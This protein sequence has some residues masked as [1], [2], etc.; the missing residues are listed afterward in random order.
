MALV[1]KQAAVMIPDHD[2]IGQLMV[3]ALEY[4]S[5]TS[6]LDELSTNIKKLGIKNSAELIAKEVVS[7]VKK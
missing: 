1:E 2:S 7:L 4:I 5:N 3:H 6:K